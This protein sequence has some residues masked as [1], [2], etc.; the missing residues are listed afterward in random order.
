[1]FAEGVLSVPDDVLDAVVAIALL[2]TL[3]PRWTLAATL[4]VEMVPG[5]ALFPTWTAFVLTVRSEAAP[6]KALPPTTE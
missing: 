4:G 6:V 2:V 1:V 3:G 5:V